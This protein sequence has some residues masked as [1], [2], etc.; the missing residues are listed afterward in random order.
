VAGDDCLRSTL[1]GLLQQK[2]KLTSQNGSNS[3]AA[4]AA[5]A[6]SPLREKQKDAYD[7]AA[8]AL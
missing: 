7:V 1:R 5:A 6:G 3:R 4:P 2:I 8:E